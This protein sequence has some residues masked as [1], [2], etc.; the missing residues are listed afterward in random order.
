[1][2]TSQR[3][4]PE[5]GAY[6]AGVPVAYRVQECAGQSPASPATGAAPA[7]DHRYGYRPV[8]PEMRKLRGPTGADGHET[9]TRHKRARVIGDLGG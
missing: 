7:A 9:G 2:H 8:R 6:P 1:M 5:T 4:Y 3:W